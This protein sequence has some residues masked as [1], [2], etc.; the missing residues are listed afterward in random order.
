LDRI[1]HLEVEV[2]S[3]R[4]NGYDSATD[5]VDFI[6]GG[7]AVEEEDVFPK[8]PMGIHAKETFHNMMKHT[9]CKIELGVSLCSCRP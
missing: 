4:M 8:A 7:V 3:F 1:L 6:F 9:M 2:T 5:V